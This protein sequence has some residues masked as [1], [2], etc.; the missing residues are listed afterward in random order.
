M[1]AGFLLLGLGLALDLAYHFLSV[2]L[3]SGEPSHSGA[4]ATALHTLVLGGM[5]V[6]FGGLLHFALSSHR[7]V[8]RKER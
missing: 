7:A 8:D 5:A 1:R 6:T 3:G 2:A 4:F